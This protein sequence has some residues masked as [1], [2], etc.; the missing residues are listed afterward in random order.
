MSKIHTQMVM[1]PKSPQSVSVSGTAAAATALG[2]N[3]KA[4]RMYLAG[5]TAGCYYVLSGTAT[6]S[7]HYLPKDLPYDISVH[8]GEVLSFIGTDGAVKITEFTQ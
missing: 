6:T 1:Y 7:G 3:I 2:A 8:G 5:A 4:I